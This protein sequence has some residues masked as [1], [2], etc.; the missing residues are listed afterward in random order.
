MK[1]IVHRAH[2]DLH[3]AGTGERHSPDL[4]R[5]VA[6]VTGGSRGV[7]R[8]VALGLGEAGAT[9]YVTGRTEREGA[10]R[11]GLPGNIHQTAEDVT[12]LGGQGVGIRCDHRNGEDVAAVFDRVVAEQG[13]LDILVN[14][15]WGGYERM[16]E[17]EV[18]TWEDP[19]WLQPLWRW[20]AMFGA[21]VRA[22]YVASRLAAR[23]MI[24][25]QSGL[26]VCVSYWAA[27]KYMGNLVYGVSKAATDRMVADMAHELMGH[28]VAA[29]SIYPGLVR[30]EAV[31]RAAAHFDLSNSESPEF[32]GRAVAALADDP[33]V[34]EKSGRVLVAAA[35]AREYGF[36]DVNGKQPRPLTLDEA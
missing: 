33:N 23:K 28:N 17:D 30:T 16:V 6:L 34:M 25:Q 35:L 12:R 14:S 20:E 1:A 11:E 31:L 2:T 21:G 18:Y 10:G 22:H 24:E 9:V 26:I 19:F 5:R 32:T 27:Q 13:R 4:T 29:V 36:V 8:G 15:V 7:G 3:D